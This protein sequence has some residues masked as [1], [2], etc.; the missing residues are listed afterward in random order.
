MDQKRKGKRLGPRKRQTNDKQNEKAKSE[1]NQAD[2]NTKHKLYVKVQTK[3]I[4]LHDDH[5]HLHNIY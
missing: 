2:H 3:Q 4:Q 5:H 1:C